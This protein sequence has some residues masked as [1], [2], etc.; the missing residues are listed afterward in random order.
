[1]KRKNLHSSV[2]LKAVS[3][4]RKAGGGGLFLGLL[5]A[6]T[7]RHKAPQGN[8]SFQIFAATTPAGERLIRK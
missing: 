2:S 4:R 8:T 5:Q 1:M 6:Q 7:R 3:T